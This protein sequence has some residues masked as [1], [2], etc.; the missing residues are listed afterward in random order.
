MTVHVLPSGTLTLTLF[1]AFCHGI[2]TVA[3]VVKLRILVRSSQLI[4]HTERRPPLF[5]TRSSWRWASRGLS[6]IAETCCTQLWLIELKFLR[7]IRHRKGHF[8][9]VSLKVIHVLHAFSHCIFIQICSNSFQDFSEYSASRCP[10][11]IAELFSE[12]ELAF[13]FT[14]CYRSSVCRL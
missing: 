2:S 4:C 9:R 14:I 5:V 11:A 6:E 8:C 7:H 3:S 10:S 13:T 12:R 1:S